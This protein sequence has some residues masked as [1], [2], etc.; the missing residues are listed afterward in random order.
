MVAAG[1]ALGIAAC[2]APLPSTNL[3]PGRAV[4][5]AL[6][7]PQLR[8]YRAAIDCRIGAMDQG[9]FARLAAA[10]QIDIVTL[11]DPAK[12]GASNFGVGGFT[13]AVLFVPGAS[14]AIDG[15]EIVATNIHNP[16][17]SHRSA[18]D[19]IRAIHDQGGLAIAANLAGFASSNDYALA[20]AVEIYNQQRAW[21]AQSPNAV[22]LRAM[23]EG[24]D[25]F[26]RALD[27]WP[28]RDLALYDEM[29]KSA[30]VTLVAGLGG[31]ERLKVMGLTVGTFQQLLLFYVTHVISPERSVDSVV[32]ALK[33]GH[34]YVSFDL[35]GYVAQ[36][37]FFAQAGDTKTMMGDEVQLA[38]GLKLSAE[39]PSAA[40]RIELLLDGTIAASMDNADALDFE[41]KSAGSYRVV[42]YRSGVPWIVSNP[43][44]VR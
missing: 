17:D 28:G 38:P 32:D 7:F 9:D 2:S 26:L 36:F 19:L 27:L 23:L 20:D 22:Y 4:A 8:D 3:P 41:P 40:D 33:H 31:E 11:G 18:T 25:R 1:L 24:T 5:P 13:E 35:L 42:A 6:E 14:Y 15:G 30:Q 44:Y 21:N 12:S 43:V 39:L 10:A 29:A 34:A 37:A 16:I